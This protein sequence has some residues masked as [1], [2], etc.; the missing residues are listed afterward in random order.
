MPDYLLSVDKGQELILAQNVEMYLRSLI[1]DPLARSRLMVPNDMRP[2][3]G[4]G[5]ATENGLRQLH[6]EIVDL[7]QEVVAGF[8]RSFRKLEEARVAY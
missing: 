7:L 5:G 4:E 3:F 2:I 8:T 1:S 6:R